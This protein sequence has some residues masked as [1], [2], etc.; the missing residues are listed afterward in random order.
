[1]VNRRRRS[2]PKEKSTGLWEKSPGGALWSCGAGSPHTTLVTVCKAHEAWKPDGGNTQLPWMWSVKWWRIPRFTN[3]EQSSETPLTCFGLLTPLLG[4]VSR[5][6]LDSDKVNL[7]GR[8]CQAL[9]GPPPAVLA[10]GAA[11]PL[12]LSEP[13][14]LPTCFTLFMKQRHGDLFSPSTVINNNKSFTYLLN[15]ILFEVRK[16]YEWSKSNI[17]WYWGRKNS[18]YFITR[19]FQ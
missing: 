4:V 5:S 2:S 7:P 12:P 10:G 9:P 11:L 15:Q 18:E 3:S 6:R 13:I 1:M 17:H 14:T 8:R 16:D 19:F